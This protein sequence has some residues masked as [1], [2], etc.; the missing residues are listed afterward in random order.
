MARPSRGPRHRHHRVHGQDHHE[1]PRARRARRRRQRVRN[2]GQPEQRARRPQH[3]AGRSGRHAKRHRRDG[4]ARPSSARGAVRVRAPAMGPCHQRRR[5]PHRASGQPREH[6]A[7]QSRAAR[8][9]ARRRHGVR[10]RRERYDPEA[11][12]VRQ[13]GLPRR[14]VRALRWH[15][16]GR[17]AS[18]GPFRRRRGASCRVVRGC[19][20]RC[21]GL[22][23][24]CAVRLRVR[25]YARACARGMRP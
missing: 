17:R 6:R 4:H 12:R 22:P 14:H 7:R 15:R 10:Q 18:C 21:V 1:E 5:K 11:A 20:S 3:R 23:A 25:R 9:V 24:F 13:P 2:E 19:A 8:G 16:S